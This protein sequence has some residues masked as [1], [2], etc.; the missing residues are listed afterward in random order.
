M[1]AAFVA[2]IETPFVQALFEI[3]EWLLKQQSQKGRDRAAATR[4]RTGNPKAPQRQN[5]GL[6]FGQVRHLA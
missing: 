1:G 5:R 6:G 4:A 2:G 3:G